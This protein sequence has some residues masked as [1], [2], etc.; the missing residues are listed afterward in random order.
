[1]DLY[2]QSWQ[3]TTWPW[4][5][6][7]SLDQLSSWNLLS[8]GRLVAPTFRS[9]ITALTAAS[10]NIQRLLETTSGRQRPKS[11]LKGSEVRHLRW[12]KRLIPWMIG[13]TRGHPTVKFSKFWPQKIECFWPKNFWIK[14]S[15][16]KKWN[17]LDPEICRHNLLTKVDYIFPKKGKNYWQK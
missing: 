2:F 9:V 7:W 4:G 12:N 8:P 5:W 16:P 10:S 6:V 13:L 3:K 17:V 11:H 14:K 15:W 1:M